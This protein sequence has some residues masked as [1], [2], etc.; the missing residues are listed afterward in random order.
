MRL[1][2]LLA[3]VVTTAACNA[4]LGLDPRPERDGNNVSGQGSGGGVLS[5]GSGGSTC[6]GAECFDPAP[7]GWLGPAL[8]S[9]GE[10]AAQCAHGSEVFTAFADL[11]DVTHTCPCTCAPATGVTCSVTVTAFSD[12]NCQNF[13]QAET[14]NSPGDCRHLDH[15]PQSTTYTETANT[16]AASCA[17]GVGE[18]VIPPVAWDTE[19][20]GCGPLEGIDTVPD[21]FEVCIHREGDEPCPDTFYTERSLLFTDVDDTRECMTDCSCGPVTTTDCQAFVQSYTG[22]TC[23]ENVHETPQAPDCVFAFFDST[24]LI[25]WS[26]TGACE[27]IDATATGTVTATGPVTV[28]CAP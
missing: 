9:R 12:E 22:H 19:V 10:T 23:N 15:D 3:L 6:Q 26:P 2:H 27:P 7:S 16:S 25:S 11:Q 1:S 14:F 18:P 24:Q 8:V 20:R 28:C 13:D 4:V 21:G 5:V 17:A